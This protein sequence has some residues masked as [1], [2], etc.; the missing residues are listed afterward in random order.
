M[1]NEDRDPVASGARTVDAAFAYA[2][3]ALVR[4]EG[5]S[6]RLRE[7]REKMGLLQRTVAM[8]LQHARMTIYRYESG[9]QVPGIASLEGLQ[10]LG[11]N[12]FYLLSG[13][14]RDS[15]G[16]RHFRLATEGFAR[17][18]RLERERIGCEQG[19]FAAALGVTRPTQS[20]YENGY[21]LP[22]LEYVAQAQRLGIDARF[23]LASQRSALMLGWS[24]RDRLAGALA[25]AS[26][27][28]SDGELRSPDA[29]ADKVLQMLMPAFENA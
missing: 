3:A 16:A 18:L 6:T 19:D 20:R 8:R 11:M 28:L 10:R 4:L 26:A 29:I 9:E 23:L 22:P 12:V 21:A 13:E 24:D 1:L 5:M 27:L 25:R 15:A 7:E 17:R 14:H 2:P